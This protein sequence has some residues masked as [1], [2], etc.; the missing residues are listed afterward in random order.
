MKKVL[1]VIDTKVKLRLYLIIFMAFLGIILESLSI[2]SV[3]PLIKILVDPEYFNTKLFFIFEKKLDDKDIYKFAIAFVLLL[4]LLKNVL[5]FILSILQA[6]FVS[7]ASA[8]LSSFF[9]TSYIKLSY[10]DFISTNS[11]QYIRNITDN[12]DYFFSTYFRSIMLIIIEVPIILILVSALFYVEPLG[13]LVFGLT[14]LSF[15]LFFYTVN[16]KKLSIFGHSI[17][18]NLTKRLSYIHK[19]FGLFKEIQISN[20]ENFYSNTFF[21]ILKNIASIG[22][23]LD[24]IV[25]LPKLFLELAGISIILT[26]IYFNLSQGGTLAEFLPTV[27]LFA[28]SGFRLM[29]SANRLISSFHKLKFSKPMINMLEDG[30]HKFKKKE[31]NPTTDKNIKLD[32]NKEIAIKDLT[33]KYKNSNSNVLS[34][35]NLNINKGDFIMILG[36]SGSGKSTLI[37]ILLG[38]INPSSGH[39]YSDNVDVFDN[40]NKW[41]KKLSHVPQ[42]VYLSDDTILSNVALGIKEE[43]IDENKVRKVLKSAQLEDFVEDLPDN[44]LTNAGEKAVRMSGGQRQR[45]AIARA[46]YRDPE[47]LLLDEATSSLD[48]ETEKKIIIDIKNNLK[49]ETI[50][51]VTHRLAITHLADKVYSIKDGKLE[52]YINPK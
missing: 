27:S 13:S 42:D 7:F 50:I 1:S 28:L 31:N 48:R 49:N 52:V 3:F 41:R 8:N 43:D 2:V 37:N 18:T 21:K 20:N 16:K 29:P 39:I 38:L 34:G 33:F 15:G 32:F 47:I 24:A 25:I 30:I 22:Y 44:I 10:I 17:N 35:F 23:K 45:M 46:L 36:P 11:A 5:L 19:S 12:V 4:F 9:F 51:M 40:L 14:A 26:L 6:K